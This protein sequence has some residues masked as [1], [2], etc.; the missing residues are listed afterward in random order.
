[1]YCLFWHIFP[2]LL[3]NIYY[4]RQGDCDPLFILVTF[5]GSF[6]RTVASSLTF[7]GLNVSKIGGHTGSDKMDH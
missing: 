6:V 1:M 7:V 5:V 3:T 4:L 2:V